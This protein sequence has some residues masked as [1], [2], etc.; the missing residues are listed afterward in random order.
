MQDKFRR[1]WRVPERM[2]SGLAI[3]EA[4]GDAHRAGACVLMIE[5]ERLEEG[6]GSRERD[7]VG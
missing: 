6:S 4:A 7:A 1:S 3:V 5:L 2:I